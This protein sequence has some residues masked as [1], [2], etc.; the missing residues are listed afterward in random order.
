MQSL[1]PYQTKAVEDVSA[2][3]SAGYNRVLLCMPTGSGKTTVV[4]HLIQTWTK[5]KLSVLLVAHRRELIA[6]A[7]NR[8]ALHGIDAGLILPGY[9]ANGHPCHVA[10]VQ[11]LARR[12]AHKADILIVDE[13]HH[14]MAGS[15]L[16][17]IGNHVDA[18]ARVL[19]L[20]ATP[21]R[22]DGK[23][24]GLVFDDMVVPTTVADLIAEGHLVKPRYFAAKK[25]EMSKLKTIAGEFDL[26]QM[27]DL[28][29]KKTLYDGVIENYVRFGGGKCIVFNV[30]IEHS[31][32]TT[33]AFKNAGFAVEHIDANT[34]EHERALVLER[35]KK[36]ETEILSNVQLFTE[37][38]DLPALD[39]VIINR[40]TKSLS[41]YTQMVGRILRPSQDK[42]HGI[43]ID[44]GN[45]IEMHGF[46]EDEQ[47]YSLTTRINKKDG[48]APVKECKGCFAIIHASAMQCRYCGYIYQQKELALKSATF[49]EVKNS[50]TSRKSP[51]PAHLRKP[52]HRMS[53]GEL[54]EVASI[55]GYKEGWVFMQLSLQSKRRKACAV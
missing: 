29:N 26:R 43:V 12:D 32:E 53:N 38:F 4:A 39:T 13:C 6:Q 35:F 18:G 44:H 15:F 45:N 20:T 23:P 7:H 1:R 19:G 10:S 25:E 27:F 46:V 42:E 41:L 40:S 30:N 48:L 5:Q 31:L 22:L 11:T 21:Y 52:W 51:L 24:L 9:H 55:R 14:S 36:G 34:P 28:F 17:I 8:L 49:E 50:P 47:D 3:F 2:S 37:G 54:R 16:K 33:Q